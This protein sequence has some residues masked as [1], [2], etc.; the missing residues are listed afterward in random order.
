MKSEGGS[1][2]PGHTTRL[3]KAANRPAL[4]RKRMQRANSLIDA[5]HV[6]LAAHIHGA[7]TYALDDIV[8]SIVR[9]IRRYKGQLLVS[10][11]KENG[12]DAQTLHR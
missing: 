4:R 1:C 5:I 8:H 3:F 2:K 7:S 6:C 9:E 10:E 11:G 12:Y